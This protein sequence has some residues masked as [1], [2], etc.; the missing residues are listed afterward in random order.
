MEMT[1]AQRLII[2]NQYHLMAMLDRH[3]PIGI[4]VC[5]P[6]LNVATVYSCESWTV[7]SVRSVKMIAVSS[8]M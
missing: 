6:L 8:S 1:N 3:R 4:V 5:R 7:T 2:S